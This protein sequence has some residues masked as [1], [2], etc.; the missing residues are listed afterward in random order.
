MLPW[1]GFGD[2]GRELGLQLA[3]AIDVESCTVVH[4]TL[5]DPVLLE[6]LLGA[7]TIRDRRLLVVDPD[8]VWRR[9]DRWI[10]LPW[11]AEPPV[12]A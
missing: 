10:V 7:E 11:S 6:P 12:T 2:A 5:P 3:D 8:C 4:Q 1:Q 9:T